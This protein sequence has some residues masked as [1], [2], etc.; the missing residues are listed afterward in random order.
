[1]WPVTPPP[2]RDV[3]QAAA[4][5]RV[6]V[7]HGRI[8]VDGQPG[9]AYLPALHVGV[10][11][12]YVISLEDRFQEKEQLWVDGRSGRSLGGP[13]AVALDRST[14]EPGPGRD[15]RSLPADPAV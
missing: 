7:D 10:L 9:A 5:D 15:H 12:E 6:A 1:P 14:A 4:R 2:D 8:D 3:L 11:I 13:L